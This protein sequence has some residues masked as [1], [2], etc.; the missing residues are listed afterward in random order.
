M[1]V[2]YGFARIGIA[3]AETEPP[4]VTARP[5]LKASGKLARDGESLVKIARNE[6]AERVVVGLPIEENGGEGRMARICR[7]VA[8]HIASAGIPVSFVDERLTSVA[9]E[10]SLREQDLKASQ[11]RRL[12]DGEA[13]RLILERFMNEQEIG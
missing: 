1:G 6:Q 5:P 13:A 8:G 11:R 7:T 9:A 4:I 2:D 3:I 12:K 10:H